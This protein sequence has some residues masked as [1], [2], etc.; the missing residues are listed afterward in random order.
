MDWSKDKSVMLSRVC[1]IIFAVILTIGCLMG[2]WIF[3]LFVKSR[4]DRLAGKLPLVLMTAYTSAIFIAIALYY[5]Y[6]L[7]KNINKEQVFLK[8]N[9]R[10]L[11]CLSWCCFAVSIIYFLS[12]FYYSTL[13]V[14]TAMALFMSLILRVVKNVFAQAEEIKRENDYTI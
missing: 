13:W 10:Y 2:P 14:L 9:V 6:Q 11:R 3:Q 4:G 1:V 5:L 12:G 8:S 7:L